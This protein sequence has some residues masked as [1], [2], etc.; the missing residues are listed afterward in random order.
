M[1]MKFRAVS[2][3]EFRHAARREADLRRPAPRH[4]DALTEAALVLAASLAFVAAID[5]ILRVAGIA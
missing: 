5:C 4:T 3:A 2:L 1:I